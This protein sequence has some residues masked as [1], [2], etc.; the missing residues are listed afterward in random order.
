MFVLINDLKAA[1]KLSKRGRHNFR[2]YLALLRDHFATSDQR[3]N[4]LLR[5]LVKAIEA[6]C[7]TNGMDID[8]L[9]K[10]RLLT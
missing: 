2:Q 6:N 4:D 5:L 1:N 3:R 7:G 10:A 8:T 9:P